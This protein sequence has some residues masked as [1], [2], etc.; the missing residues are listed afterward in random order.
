MKKVLLA[1]LILALFFAACGSKRSTVL[2]H[3]NG[4]SSGSVNKPNSSSSG[5][6]GTSVS[7]IAY[8]DRYKGIAIEEMNKYGIPASIKLAQAILESGNG[9]SYLATN[10][11]NHFGI[12]CGGTWNG[13]SVNRP[14]DTD[15]DCFRVYNDP[16]QS[17]RD[18]SQFLLRKRYENLFTLRKD[19]YKGWARGLKAAGYATNPRYPEL[20]I[21]LIERYNLQQY[22]QAEAPVEV[23]ARVE[24]V[25]EVIEE[26][27]VE[28]PQTQVEEIKKPVAM[29]IYEVKATDTMYSIAKKYS[30][31][32]DAIKQWNGLATDTVSL[33]QL[34]VVSK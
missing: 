7:G 34:L 8:I 14:D 5:N 15:N 16:E 3:P 6:K 28:E 24:K 18:H 12:K 31:T 1:S 4:T 25:E 21:D 20:L 29:A 32:V 11:N 17:F 22:D 13:K 10:A 33:G 19:D 9:N 26:K 30:V 23:V 2:K 27:E